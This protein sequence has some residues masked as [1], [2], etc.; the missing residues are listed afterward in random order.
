MIT[1]H[2]PGVPAPQGSKTAMPVRKNGKLTGKTNQV[3]SS[4]AL[5]PWRTL[6]THQGRRAKPKGFTPYV[7]AVRVEVIFRFPRP[8]GHYGT[9]RNA[10][11]LK[12]SAP[13]H[14]IT[15]PDA[16]KLLRAIFDGLT[17]AGI[18]RD[19]SQVIET[20]AAKRYA[21]GDNPGA[22]ISVQPI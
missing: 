9:G 22:S 16:D 14:H 10:G 4:K 18:Y 17:A 12:P 6:V 20:Y 7:G 1:F 15:K 19:D 13:E 21:H 2:V 8:K 11:T 3:E 5:Q